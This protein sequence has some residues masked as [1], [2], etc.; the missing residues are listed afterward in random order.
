MDK[1]LVCMF[2]S[3]WFLTPPE[4]SCHPQVEPML[5]SYNYRRVDSSTVDLAFSLVMM[6][7]G[8]GDSVSSL[9]SCR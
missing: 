1:A 2:R 9:H 6:K 4:R 7:S 8:S 3:L 5:G